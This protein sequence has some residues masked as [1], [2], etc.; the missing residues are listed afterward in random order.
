MKNEE[1]FRKALREI[2]QILGPHPVSC[3]QIACEGC[4]YEMRSALRVA[5][6]ALRLPGIKVK[7]KKAASRKSVPVDLM[8]DS[9]TPLASHD[10]GWYGRRWRKTWVVSVRRKARHSRKRT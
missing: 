9:D 5:R 3:S 4:V 7:G 8:P 6:V 1:R 10:P 2:Y